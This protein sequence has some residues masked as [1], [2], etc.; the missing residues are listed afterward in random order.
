MATA[1]PPRSQASAGTS[2]ATGQLTAEQ[3]ALIAAM[4]ASTTAAQEALANSTVAAVQRLYAEL[5]ADNGWFVQRRVDAIVDD[6]TDVMADSLQAA[7]DLTQ[8]W[9]EGVLDV[10]EVDYRDIEI[11]VDPA[12]RIGVT[13]EREWNRPAEQARVSRLL[14]A[15]EFQ[16][17][18]K[19]LIRAEQQARTDLRLARREAEQ[20]MWGVSGDII[21]YRRILRPELSQ[22]GPCGLCVVA[23][24]RVYQKS[25][26]EPLHNGCVCDVLP[27]VK[28]SSGTILDP[29]FDLN[30]DDL[31]VLYA[32]GGGTGRQGLQRV[33]L[34]TIEHGELGPTLVDGRYKTRE[35]AD[36]VDL[37]SKGLDPQRVYDAQVKIIRQY[38]KAVAEGRRPQF[39]IDFHRRIRDDYA[40]RLGIKSDAA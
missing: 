6:V 28:D 19:A 27:I 15:D 35:K 34:K 13:P 1:A 14:G 16:A 25:E 3:A 37:A 8:G 31:K 39:D 33:R 17:N 7:A 30:E 36:V 11:D 12:V 26:L 40:K 4:L 38:E 32:A 2:Q 21:S 10:L 9:L 23:A 22:T 29:G 24:S 20:E 18:E 5:L